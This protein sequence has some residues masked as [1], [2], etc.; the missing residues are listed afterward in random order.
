[1]SYN[2]DLYCDE[3]MMCSLINRQKYY[4]FYIQT[5]V[6]VM[7]LVKGMSYALNNPSKE[8]LYQVCCSICFFVTSMYLD[9]LFVFL[10]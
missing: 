3:T 4:Y 6:F 5:I 7:M 8:I 2:F 9:K 10:N 1:M